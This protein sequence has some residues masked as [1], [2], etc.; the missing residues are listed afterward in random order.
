MKKTLITL[1]ALAGVAAA[2]TIDL[3]STVNQDSWTLGDTHDSKNGTPKFENGELLGQGSW[4]RGCASYDLE[5]ITL[6]NASDGLSISFTLWGADVDEL[7]T[8]TIIGTEQAIV[9]G[10]GNYKAGGIYYG[11]TTTLNA[12]WYNMQ[13]SS[14]NNVPADATI[15][16]VSNS[17]QSA[18]F[19]ASTDITLTTDI[20]WDATKS[21]FVA[22]LSYVTSSDTKTQLATYDLGTTYS[23]DKIVLSF[24]GGGT[25]KFKALTVKTIPEPATATLSL[26]ALAGLAARRRRK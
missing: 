12:D 18:I 8:C 19:T 10:Q 3:F 6:S 24:D 2:E 15:G 21:Q 26:L 11:T 1:L 20:A 13:S 16:Y 25:H 14:F 7:L 9:A 4:A 22:T 17:K 23:L 5:N